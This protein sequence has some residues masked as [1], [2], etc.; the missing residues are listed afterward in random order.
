MGTWGTGAFDNDTAADW[1]YALEQVDD[2]SLID[3]TI[4]SVLDCDDDYP[5]A[6]LAA[7][8]IAACE[9]VA[10]LR[11]RH[12]VRDDSTETVDNWV[13]THAQSPSKALLESARQAIGR[14]LAEN[15]ELRELWAESEGADWLAAV[16]DLRLR[17]S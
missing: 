10:R 17:L 1:S 2:L 3:A 11:G 6:D 16:E 15:S 13:K 7:E 4:A 14:V 5:D 9:V 8:A 12:G